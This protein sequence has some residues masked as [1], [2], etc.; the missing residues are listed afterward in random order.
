MPGTG[1]SGRSNGVIKEKEMQAAL[2][3]KLPENLSPLVGVCRTPI[4]GQGKR[5]GDLEATANPA[6]SLD[7]T[8]E[9]QWPSPALCCAEV[10]LIGLEKQAS[11]FQESQ[12]EPRY[13]HPATTCAG[14]QGS[15][16]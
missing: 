8:G 15:F 6:P 16:P 7:L 9:G 14:R 2:S 1:V 4:P 13:H 11:N 3:S 12:M 5:M 10:L